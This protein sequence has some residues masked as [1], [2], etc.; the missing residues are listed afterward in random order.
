MPFLLYH[1]IDSV[2]KIVRQDTK[3]HPFP[4]FPLQVACPVKT[5]HYKN[6]FSELESEN[7]GANSQLLNINNI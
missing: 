3:Q 1:L 5:I 7:K 4:G 6:Y 2:I